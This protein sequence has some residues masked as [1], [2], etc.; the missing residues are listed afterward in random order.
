MFSL[1]E[2]LR[3]LSINNAYISRIDI[4]TIFSS[5]ACNTNLT[6]IDLSSTYIGNY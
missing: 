3:T 2:E 4:D 5:L 1:E 6:T